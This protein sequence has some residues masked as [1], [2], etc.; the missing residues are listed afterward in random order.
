MKLSVTPTCEFVNRSSK[1]NRG[2]RELPLRPMLGRGTGAVQLAMRDDS[3]T[4]VDENKTNAR[5]TKLPVVSSS[6]P[7]IPSVKHV[8]IGAV[9]LA[10]M[11]RFVTR[12]PE[13]FSLFLTAVFSVVISRLAQNG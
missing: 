12:N 7:A 1:A 2:H 5:S 4:A 3:A 13:L 10:A 9:L 6:P 8:R 11:A